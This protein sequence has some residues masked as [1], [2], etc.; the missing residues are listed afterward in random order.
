MLFNPATASAKIKEE[1]IDYIATSF[2]LSDNEYVQ[3]LKDNLNQS[4]VISKGPMIDIKDIFKSGRSIEDL[5]SDGILSPLFKEIEK[6]KP[7]IDPYKVKLPLTRPL[8]VHQ[9]NAIDIISTKHNNAVITTGTGSGKTECFLIPVINELLRQKEKGELNAG[10]RAILI[11][12]MNALANDQMKRLREILMFYPDI[13]FGVYNG[14]TKYNREDAELSYNYLHYNEACPEL[15]SHLE[16]ELI[17]REEMNETPPHILCTNYAMLEHMLLKPE[18]DAIF[19]NSDFRFV[20]LDEAHIYTG[21]TGMETALLLRRLQARIKTRGKTQYI[22]TSATLG[23]ENESK[24][25]IINFAENLCGSKFGN[26]DIIFGKR[27]TYIKSDTTLDIP[28]NMF[29]ELANSEPEE[30]Q[31]IFDNY[32]I[33]YND[34]IDWKENIYNL[35]KNSSYYQTI[36]SKALDPTDIKDFAKYLGIS[37]DETVSFIH[38][39]TLAYKNGKALIDAKYHFFIRALEGLYTPLMG[40]KQI[41]LDRKV[42]T[43]YNGEDIAVF[44][45]AACTNCGELGIVGKIEPYPTDGNSFLNLAAQHDLEARYFHI[46]KQNESN[47]EELDDEDEILNDDNDKKETNKEKKLK[48]YYLCP[49]CGKITEIDDGKPK[50]ECGVS[51]LTISEYQNTDGKCPKCQTGIYRRFYLGSEAATGVLATTLFEELPTKTIKD[52]DENDIEYTY[53]GGKQFLTFSDSRSEAAFFASYMDKIYKEFLRRR[54]FLYTLDKLHD[55]LIDEP[56]HL[57]ELVEEVA[58]VFTKNKSFINDLSL[59]PTRRELKKEAERNAWIAVLVEVISSRR[60]SSLASFGQVKFE[61]ASNA[62]KIV[63]ALAKKY[64]IDQKVCKELLDYLALTIA[65]FGALKFDDDVLEAD[66]RKYIFFTDEQKI[67]VKQKTAA[68]NRYAMSWKARNREGK[69]DSFYLNSRVNLVARILKCDIAKANEFL[70]DYFEKWLINKRENKYSLTQL[71]KGLALPVDAFIVCVPGDEEAHWYKCDCCGKVTTFNGDGICPEHNCGGLLKET[72]VSVSGNHY[73]ELYKKKEF[74]PLLIKEH[75][76][77]LSREEGLE[78]QKMFEKNKIHALSCSTTFE[79]GV[80]VGE[81]ETVFLRNVPPS[82]ANYAQR[83]GR[84]GRSKNAAAYSLTYAK[85]SSHDFTY[86][87]EPK[88]I[89]VGDVKPPKF[90]IDN[91]K[92]VLR[93]IYAVVLSYFFQ[94]STIDY[95]NKNNAELFLEQNGYEELKNMI[96]NMP[97]DLSKILHASIPNVDNYDWVEKFVGENGVLTSAINEYRET[98][99]TLQEDCDFYYAKRDSPNANKVERMIKR[100]KTN[101]TIEFLVRSNVIPKYGFPIDS[102]E[103]EVSVD[104]NKKSGLNLSRD[105]K[106]AISEYA[107]GEKVIADGKMYTSRYIKKSFFPHGMDYYKTYVAQCSNDLCRTW[108]YSMFDPTNM[109]KKLKC[110]TCH[111]EINPAMWKE[112]IEPRAGF[113]SESKAE[114]VPLRRPERVYRSQDSYIGDGKK[115]KDYY[116]KVGDH[117]LLI[118]SSENDEIMVTSSDRF[119]VCPVCGCAYGPHDV[120]YQGRGSSKKID[121]KA[122]KDLRNGNVPYIKLKGSHV[123]SRGLLCP[124]DTIRPYYLNHI[125]K[126]DVVIVDFC[127][128][129]PIDIDTAL[130]VLYALLNAMSDVLGIDISDIGGTLSGSASSSFGQIS[131]SL[132]LY[133]TVAGG[134]GHVGRIKSNASILKTILRNAYERVSECTCDTS[135]Y[136]CLRSYS[137]QR[138]HDR[139]DRNKAADFLKD[140]L[141]DVHP[142]EQEKFAE[143][144]TIKLKENGKSMKNVSFKEIFT[145]NLSDAVNEQIVSKLIEVFNDYNLPAPLRSEEDFIVNGT[146]IMYADLI[147]TKEKVMVFSPDNYESYEAAKYSEYECIML[148]DDLDINELVKKLNKEMY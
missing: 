98:C 78:Y 115:I 102:V 8:Y 57:S 82:A 58:K 124:G 74:N 39:C 63:D 125:Y 51:F 70:D 44:E 114:E 1:F 136:S 71:E 108:N 110:V 112:A 40:D 134:A 148:D 87:N 72:S 104:E 122:T 23:K 68:T 109:D 10:V 31:N 21:A 147:W 28:A 6:N 95:F 13:T 67:I 41:F 20:V 61:Y 24:D 7:K 113:V 14:D 93:H 121:Q 73:L 132:V 9:E 50:C 47:F 144:K 118:R 145:K 141:Y 5:I 22:L 27:E 103:L 12:P 126:T 131:Y 29:V 75:T 32:S 94:N 101:K 119:Y 138:I 56:F 55:D 36:R 92:I 17:S 45:R 89:I 128:N 76:A 60:R 38:V 80:D 33:S 106:L 107:P 86:F 96:L 43:K 49:K 11:Y 25:P 59:I 84:A 137:N 15:R 133:D 79:M 18:N 83:A 35:C 2:S 99:K 85:L 53:E 120:L 81:L 129:A 117:D 142:Y 30:Y 66:D 140:Y 62:P 90:K 42:K 19:K 105:L 3:L 52:L 54:A 46:E 100:F 65:Q 116:Y 135:C 4:G 26:D 64:S 130:S 127:D 34:S 91:E 111:K 88:K 143:K 69:V 97:E 48:K 16:N 37:K 123:N 139:L 77:Q 146:S